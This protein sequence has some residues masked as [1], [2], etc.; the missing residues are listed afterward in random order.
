MEPML[1]GR[2]AN[3]PKDIQEIFDRSGTKRSSSCWALQWL[4]NQPEVSL[5][6]SGMSSMTQLDENLAS[7]G[8]SGVG[9][10]GPEDLRIIEAVRRKYDERAAIPCTGCSYCMPCP[11]NVS[12]PRN[13]ELYNGSVIH[14][15]LAGSRLTYNNFFD[16]SNR[17]GQCIQC[18]VCEEKCP[19]RIP[20][21]EWM[22][23]VH[24]ALG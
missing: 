9:L 5:V 4:W 13:F 14:D 16:E 6:L 1:G 22:P 20:I 11:N 2:L 7:A 17:A 19:Q 23:K 10:F 3:P 12:I 21:S 8:N 24:K 18:R 15:D